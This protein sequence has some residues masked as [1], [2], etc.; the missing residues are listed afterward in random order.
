[1]FRDDHE[2]LLS[3]PAFLGVQRSSSSRWVVIDA[4]GACSGKDA[5]R[6]QAEA[7]EQKHGSRQRALRNSRHLAPIG[8]HTLR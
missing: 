7:E 3:P 6:D 1:M 4:A 5:A 2:K 8:T